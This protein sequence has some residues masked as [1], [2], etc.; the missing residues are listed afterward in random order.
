MEFWRGHAFIMGMVLLLSACAST[1]SATPPPP[2]AILEPA[3]ADNPSERLMIYGERLRWLAP[4]SLD[5]ERA[6]AEEDYRRDPS[7][8][9][10]LR[11]ALLLALRRAPFRDDMRARDLLSQAATERGSSNQPLRSFAM[12]LLQDF[13]DR[14]AAERAL[15]EERRQRL[16]LQK[17]LDQ[18]KAVE[19]DMDRRA[20]PSVVTPR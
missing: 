17:K 10:R 13:D 8:F 5:A 7:A 2:R 14:W 18:L 16:T 1:R 19:E 11:L 12:W 3:A 15:D 4:S 20:S 6:A 9:N